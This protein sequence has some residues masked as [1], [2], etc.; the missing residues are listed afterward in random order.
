MA[1]PNGGRAFV[2]ARGRAGTITWEHSGTNLRVSIL[3]NSAIRIARKGVHSFAADVVSTGHSVLFAY[4]ING[5]FA[6]DEIGSGYLPKIVVPPATKPRAALVRWVPRAPCCLI[7]LAPGEIWVYRRDAEDTECIARDLVFDDL[8]A[9][10]ACV[11]G[12]DIRFSVLTTTGYLVGS[13]PVSGHVAR[14][15]YH[16]DRSLGPCVA[17]AIAQTDDVHRVYAAADPPCVVVFSDVAVKIARIA[18]SAFC[19]TW[20]LDGTYAYDM[21]QPSE[22]VYVGT[23]GTLGAFSDGA[24]FC[25]DL[26]R[27]WGMSRVRYLQAPLSRRFNISRNLMRGLARALLVVFFVGFAVSFSTKYMGYGQPMVDDPI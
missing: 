26:S 8:V 18:P 4:M 10:D 27:M 21:R 12:G 13:V 11:R 16:V 5:E 1:R 3:Q 24:V 15:S 9:M 7:A 17:C 20:M 14:V 19:G 22:S 25:I 2:D 23:S 6:V